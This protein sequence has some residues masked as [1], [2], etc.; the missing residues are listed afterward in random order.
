MV[1]VQSGAAAPSVRN[2]QR[3]DQGQAQN[4]LP[5]LKQSQQQSADVE[6]AY[7]SSEGDKALSKA[8]PV[9]EQVEV[10]AAAPSIDAVSSPEP[11]LTARNIG[12][13]RGPTWSITSAG[14]L[15]RSLDNGKT[16]QDVS[17]TAIPAA[18]SGLVAEQVA[19]YGY[20][21]KSR[22]KKDAKAAKQQASGT[23]VFRAVSA[24]GLDVWAG[25]SAGALFHSADAGD[26][27]T[28]IFPLAGSTVLTADITSIQFSDLRNGTITTATSEVWTTA[29]AGRSWHKQ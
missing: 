28:R 5:D 12:S 27:W 18:V 10:T 23:P 29:D 3:Q 24:N 15:Q 25:G 21:K 7:A 8:K 2:G 26:H 16:W 17:V 11:V 20:E 1:E 22:D 6:H 14:G 4:Q 13:L 19:V 9:P